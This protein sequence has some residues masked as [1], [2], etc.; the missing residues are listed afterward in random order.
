MTMSRA[1]LEIKYEKSREGVGP[2]Y[3]YLMRTTVRTVAT[4]PTSL[5]NALVVHKGDKTANEL[6]H[7]VG[8]RDDIIISPLEELPV[9]VNRFSAD[10]LT[11]MGGLANG[12]I[13]VIEAH[14]L[15]TIWT[16]FY[17]QT[18]TFYAEVIDDSDPYDVI[19]NDPGF[20]SF[21]RLLDFSVQ[22]AAVTIHDGTD[23]VAN[24]D[25]TGLTGIDFLAEDHSDTWNSFEEAD[26]KYESLRTQAQSLVD[27][28][29]ADNFSGVEQERYQ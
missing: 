4:T 19:V 27:A 28:V 26:N 20:P 13:I 18:T 15:P 1:R 5:Y 14:N 9:L 23:G 2:L 16:R 6:L 29:N 21:A 17:S 12:D 22:R 8:T 24:R 11:G 7:R 25:Y 10:S 3:E